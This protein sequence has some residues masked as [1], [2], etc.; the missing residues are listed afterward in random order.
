M[1]EQKDY[2]RMAVFVDGAY[3]VEITQMTKRTENG[4][5]Q[6]FTLNEGL[7]GFTPGSGVCTVSINYVIPASGFEFNFDSA[8]VKRG[9]HTLQVSAG[10]HD[11][12]G[13]GKFLDNEISQS[14]GATT[15]G[16]VNW[17]GE[18]AEFE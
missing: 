7:G 14:T 8:C 9:Y 11:Y 1:A 13:E 4:E 18:F 3:Q 5:Q 17:T 10:A 2:A 6:V 15:E 12:I 16:S